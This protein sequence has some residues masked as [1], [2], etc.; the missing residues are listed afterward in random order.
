MNLKY[1]PELF[2]KLLASAGIAS[3]LLQRLY[4][5]TSRPW[6]RRED[7]EAAFPR[8][9]NDGGRSPVRFR[10]FDALRELYLP[11]DG[12]SFEQL[13]VLSLLLEELPRL[14]FRLSR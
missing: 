4:I 2:G 1:E 5:G 8:A 11:C 14:I 6:D 13:D 9:G 7:F 3:S 12:I 10:S